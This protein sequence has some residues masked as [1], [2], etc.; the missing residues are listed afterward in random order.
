MITC[1]G[2]SV[3]YVGETNKKLSGRF[4]DHRFRIKNPNSASKATILVDHFNYVMCKGPK[5]KVQIIEKIDKPGK[6]SD[7]KLN[8]ETAC[9]RRQ[10]ETFW[11]KELRTIYPYGLN[12]RCDTNRDQRSIDAN[13]YEKLNKRKKKNH[14]KSN[15]KVQKDLTAYN[16]L[17]LQLN[18]DRKNLT[19]VI[20]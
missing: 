14:H 1:E 20:K 10:R 8:K 4:T 3:Q 7:G 2:C 19:Y 18:T 5:Y 11:I 9:L 12:N 6:N 15:K 16:V 17:S 13:L